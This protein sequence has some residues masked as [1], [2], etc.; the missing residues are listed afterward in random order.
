[1]KDIVWNRIQNGKRLGTDES[2]WLIEKA[3]LHDLG[4]WAHLVRC[5]LHPPSR[6]TYQVDR[7]INYTNTCI[8]GCRFCAFSRPPGHP[9]GWTLTIEEVCAKVEDTRA[10]GGTG[11]LLQGGHNPEIPFQYYVD[12]L[13]AIRRRFPEI[14]IHAFSPPEIAAFSE[15][16]SMP[17][18]DVLRNLI[19]A[20]IDSVPG[21]GAE[22]L[23]ETVRK[24][25]SPGKCSAGEWLEITGTCHD[26]GLRTTATMVI[27]L[28]E[29]VQDRLKHLLAIRELQ[30]RTGG[31]TAFIPWTFQSENTVLKDLEPMTGVDY[32]RI[33]AAAR[34]VLDNVQHHQVSWV[35]QGLRLGSIALYYGADDFSSV[36]MEEKVVASAGVRMSATEDDLRKT[37]ENAGFRPVKRLT[38]YQNILHA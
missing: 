17:V 20:G 12:L 18:R 7:N 26:L 14:H 16:F 32:L 31:F 15:F 9:N 24:K 10:A 3:G 38:L 2:L 22:I 36:M 37:I 28:G 30:D 23:S 27:G 34:I 33:Q 29:T 6:V 21:G 8:S 5:R 1:M 11:I 4:R 13:S 19:D 35:T 25:M